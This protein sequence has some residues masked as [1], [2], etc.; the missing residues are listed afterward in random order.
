MNTKLLT[1]GGGAA[2]AI[3]L[4]YNN[5]Q[6]FKNKD[7]KDGYTA[8]FFTPGPFGILFLAGFLYEVT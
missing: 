6:G 7:F 3:Y 4:V 1:I 2:L 8:G 5:Q